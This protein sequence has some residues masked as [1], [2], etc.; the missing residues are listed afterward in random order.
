MAFICRIL[1]PDLLKDQETSQVASNL[2]EQNERSTYYNENMYTYIK[3][4][5]ERSLGALSEHLVL[6]KNIQ[7]IYSANQTQ[8]SVKLRR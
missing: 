7:T 8:L 6:L 2:V 3:R 4:I 1:R 5:S